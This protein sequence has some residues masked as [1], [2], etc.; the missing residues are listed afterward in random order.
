[1]WSA[2][3]NGTNKML[4]SSLQ[5]A[6]HPIA[7]FALGVDSTKLWHPDIDESIPAHPSRQPRRR[8]RFPLKSSP[9]VREKPCLALEPHVQ[10]VD[11]TQ[12]GKTDQ[13]RGPCP[14]VFA[15]I[16]FRGH[17]WRAVEPESWTAASRV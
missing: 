8:H 14:I 1:M 7:P 16:A 3:C 12:P 6:L 5:L 10:V 15:S 11:T 2:L 13:V 4:I 9:R 17:G